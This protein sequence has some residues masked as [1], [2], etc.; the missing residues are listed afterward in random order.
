LSIIFLGL[1]HQIM[2]KVQKYTSIKYKCIYYS[3]PFTADQEF[4]KG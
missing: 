1:G 4:I 3:D 2:D